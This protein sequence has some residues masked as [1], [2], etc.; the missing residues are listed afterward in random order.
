MSRGPVVAF[1]NLYPAENRMHA[2]YKYSLRNVRSKQNN[3]LGN[4]SRAEKT[5]DNGFSID[6]ERFMISAA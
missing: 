4:E 5:D 2:K 3:V 6:R 1:R